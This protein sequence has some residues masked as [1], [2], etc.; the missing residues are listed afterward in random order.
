[1]RKQLLEQLTYLTLVRI[2]NQAKSL[3][4]GT[5][6]ALK[7]LLNLPGHC[8]FWNGFYSLADFSLARM[9]HNPGFT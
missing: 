8:F 7:N 1:M 5:V 4:N 2:L 6:I 9:M 3:R